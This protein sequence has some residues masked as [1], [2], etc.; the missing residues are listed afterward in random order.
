VLVDTLLEAKTFE[1][2]QVRE[3]LQLIEQE[4]RR[5]S[6]LIENVLTLARLEKR[7][8]SLAFSEVPGADIVARV[9][10]AVRFS[11]DMPPLRVEAAADLPTIR[12]DA[13]ALVAALR[14]PPTATSGSASKTTGSGSRLL[15]SRRSSAGFTR[16]SE[17]SPAPAPDAVLA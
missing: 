12:C 1:A 2:G 16:S 7:G 3:Y 17:R 9:A 5:L 14:R 15:I 4:N 13:D 11:Q 8:S 6:R 10:Q